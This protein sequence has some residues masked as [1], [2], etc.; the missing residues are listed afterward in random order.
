MANVFQENN[1]LTYIQSSPPK[2][3]NNI[4]CGY[5]SSARTQMKFNKVQIDDLIKHIQ[6]ITS[7][8]N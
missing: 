6:L 1:L 5:Q 2:V 8:K 3:I 7:K 4:Y